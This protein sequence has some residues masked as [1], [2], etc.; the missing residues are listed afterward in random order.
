MALRLNLRWIPGPRIHARP[1]HSENDTLYFAFRS[2]RPVSTP[3]PGSPFGVARTTQSACRAAAALGTPR[4]TH[5]PHVRQPGRD[6]KWHRP[7]CPSAAR[8]AVAGRGRINRASPEPFERGHDVTSTVAAG[9]PILLGRIAYGRGRLLTVCSTET[10]S[11]S[12]TK[13]LCTPLACASGSCEA[14]RNPR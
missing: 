6:S 9:L 14:A 8:I 5:S 13:S 10:R 7:H 1:R 11:A 3:E 2:K 12:E 4:P